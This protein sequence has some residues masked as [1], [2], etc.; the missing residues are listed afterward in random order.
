MKKLGPEALPRKRDRR[1]VIDELPDEVL[2]Y[3]LDRHKAH[4]LNLT[5]ALVWRACDGK[6]SAPAIGRRLTRELQ[7]PFSEDL[8]WL[9]LRHL[10]RLHLLDESISLPPRFAG[11]SRRE[12][13]RNLGIAAAVSLPVVTSIISPTAAEA[14]SCGGHGAT[15]STPAQCCSGSCLS[16]AC[17]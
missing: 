8:V 7:A 3:D 16:N 14:N 17:V 10:E 15:C 4:C 2:V 11:V 6:T 13:I 1:L 9:A 12:M 5:A